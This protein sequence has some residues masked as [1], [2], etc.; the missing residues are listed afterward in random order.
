MLSPSTTKSIRIGLVVLTTVLLYNFLFLS[1]GISDRTII[2]KWMSEMEI[3]IEKSIIHKA[4]DWGGNKLYIIEV[5]DLDDRG[6]PLTCGT[7][8]EIT[9]GGRPELVSYPESTV[10]GD[11]TIIKQMLL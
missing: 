11:R 9:K 4:P 5:T 6:Y 2:N 8:V 10:C 3:P 1:G 7:M